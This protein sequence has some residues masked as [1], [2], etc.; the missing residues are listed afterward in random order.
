MTSIE[1]LNE[2]L[3]NNPE[4]LLGIETELSHLQSWAEVNNFKDR[5]VENPQ[6]WTFEYIK[7]DWNYKIYSYTVQMWD[8]INL[9][10]NKADTQLNLKSKIGIQITSTEWEWFSRFA[11]LRM[12]QKVHIMVPKNNFK[13]TVND[14]IEYIDW[15]KCK[16]WEYF[17]I[18][19]SRFNNAVGRISWESEE[20]Y[21]ARCNEY[22]NNCYEGF[23]N[24]NNEKRNSE[25]E[26]VRWIS[27]IYIRAWD[28]LSSDIPADKNSIKNWTNFIK[29][30]NEEE[31]IKNN[32]EQIASWFYWT[33]T[34]KKNRQTQ[35]DNFLNIY[36]EYKNIPWWHNLVPMLDLE[37]DRFTAEIKKSH[38]NRRWK[39]VVDERYKPQEFKENALHWLQ[40]VEEKT[41]VIPGIYIWAKAYG[42]YVKWDKRFDKY[43]TRITAYPGSDNKTGREIGTARRINFQEWSVNI[44]SQ[45]SPIDIKPDMYQ[46]SQEWSVAWASAEVTEKDKSKHMDTDMDHTKDITK[47][48]EENNKSSIQTLAPTVTEATPAT[49]ETTPTTPET[50]STTPETAPTPPETTPVTPEFTKLKVSQ[51]WNY[52]VYS[53]IAPKWATPSSVKNEAVN[54]N[55]VDNKNKNRILVTDK[56][57]TS[58]NKFQAWDK[59][60]IK[61]P[62]F[63]YIRNSSDNCKVYSYMIQK[64]WTASAL[65]NKASTA[66]NVEKNK[67]SITDKAWRTYSDKH[68]FTKWEKVYIKVK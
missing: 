7:D 6:I 37:T 9:I 23:K 54:K 11:I 1:S 4:E 49:P 64:G 68:T 56:N 44:W 62:L 61:I 43:L 29:K 55:L 2:H 51:D 21:N 53:Y 8:S 40:Y 15:M 13:E 5:I 63:L 3:D 65:K 18:D 10:T 24:R 20:S 59:I 35:A 46:S 50:T 60:Y 31:T 22:R 58:I 16:W 34:N 45:V 48:F 27:F 57:W 17:W 41:W 30:Y 52:M 28:G 32:S 38:K 66:L 33:L 67:I 42:S 39:T 26:D 25:K 14:N 47:L 19:V 12:G 36:N